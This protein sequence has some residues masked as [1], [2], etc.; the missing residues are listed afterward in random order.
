MPSV[1]ANAA[2][3][4]CLREVLARE[5]FALNRQRAFGETGVDVVATRG[6]EKIFIEVTGFKSS[7][8][9]RSKDFYE[10]FFRAVSRLREGPGK[11][12]IALPSRAELGLPARA[13]QYG[14]AWHRIGRAFPELEIW[15]VDVE[16]RTYRRTAWNDWAR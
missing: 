1:I 3:E 15:L 6:D 13:G 7:G 4:A 9:A 8:P 2:V 14:E 10:S 12:A 16:K 5:G 11:L